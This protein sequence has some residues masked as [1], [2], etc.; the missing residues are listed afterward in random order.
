[1]SNIILYEY[2]IDMC[3]CVCVCTYMCALKWMPG[4]LRGFMVLAGSEF[5]PPPALL[6]FQYL[7]SKPH[8]SCCLVSRG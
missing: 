1:M 4:I 7:C 6:D 2:R 5:H 3:V 8:S